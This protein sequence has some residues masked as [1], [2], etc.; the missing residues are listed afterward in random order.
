[1][2]VMVGPVGIEA[3]LFFVLFTDYYT[4]SYKMH[5]GTYQSQLHDNFYFPPSY[6]STLSRCILTACSIKEYC[7]VCCCI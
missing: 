7:I 1:V 2:S 3:L 5:V 6:Y 4:I